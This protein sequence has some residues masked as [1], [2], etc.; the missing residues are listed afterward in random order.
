MGFL[1]TKIS[2]LDA[3]SKRYVVVGNKCGNA[4]VREPA[5]HLSALRLLAVP[6]V[7]T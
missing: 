5:S 3:V 6:G 4:E 2:P 1:E 7:P